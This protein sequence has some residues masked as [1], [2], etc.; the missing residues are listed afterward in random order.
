MEIAEERPA[1]SQHDPLVDD[2]GGEFGGGM[3]KRHLD[4]FDD[5]T[6][7]FGKALGDLTLADHDFL[8]HPVHQVP[9]FDLHHAPLAVLRHAC[10]PDLLLDPFG[11][12]LADEEIMVAS[13]I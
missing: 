9:S 10:R 7:R 2:V 11:A 5:R 13:D 1:A 12:T 6:D 8:W 4:S 3:F